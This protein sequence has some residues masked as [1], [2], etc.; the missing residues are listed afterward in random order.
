M[1]FFKITEVVKIMYY[2]FSTV[3]S[4]VLI[5]TKNGLATF[6]EIFFTNSSGRTVAAQLQANVRKRWK[7]R[8]LRT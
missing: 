1:F 3:L 6:S 4:Y 7:H 5:L 2:S 8:N